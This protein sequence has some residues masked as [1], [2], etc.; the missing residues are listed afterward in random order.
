MNNTI[1]LIPLDQIEPHPGN[2]RI[3]GFDEAKLAQLADSIKAVGVQ[4]PAVVRMIDPGNGAPARYQLVAGERRWRASRI[5]GNEALPCVVRELDDVAAMKIQYIENLQRDDIHPLDEADGYEQLIARAGYTVETVAADVGKSASYVYQRLKLNSL[6]DEAKKLFA[7][8]KI[9]AG[10]AI[11]MARLGPDQQREIIG[12]RQRNGLFDYKRELISVRA[13]DQW[14]RDN[15]MLELSKTTWKMDDTELLPEAGSCRD[16]AKRTGYQPELFADVCK[17]G[18]KDY[19]T[20]RKCFAGK[21]ERIVEVQREKL[22]G[23]EVLEVVD[24]YVY[25]QDEPKN[26]ISNCDWRECKK[27]EPGAKKVLVVAGKSP[28]R[29]TYGVVRKE[30]RYQRSPEEKAKLKKERDAARATDEKRLEKVMAILEAAGS[31]G[32]PAEALRVC[33]LKVWDRWWHDH[34]V[35]AAKTEGWIKKN[36]LVDE[37]GMKRIKAMDEG[38]LHRMLLLITMSDEIK[39]SPYGYQKPETITALEKVYS[40]STPPAKK[41]SKK[42]K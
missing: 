18:K 13:L 36:G 25:G 22:A 19:C 42:K 14:I 23:E 40:I 20:D 39:A 1:E 4:Q 31:K 33:V 9:T 26:A 34:K 29:T 6:V 37:E 41:P 38:K 2:R 16:C 15:I 32:M 10:H 5:A 30:E 3:G 11:L 24:G 35:I 28:G 12:T 8:N 7:G 27:S 17:D 21:Q